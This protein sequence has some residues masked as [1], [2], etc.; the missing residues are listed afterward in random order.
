MDP[1]GRL[2]PDSTSHELDHEVLECL[3]RSPIRTRGVAPDNL[4]PAGQPLRRTE[5]LGRPCAQRR[6]S[7]PYVTRPVHIPFGY[8]RHSSELPRAGPWR[9]PSCLQEMLI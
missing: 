8:S 5:P 6:P 4:Q 2:E 7:W 9:P 1:H 3:P